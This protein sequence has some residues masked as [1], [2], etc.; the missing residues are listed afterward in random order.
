MTDRPVRHL[1][2]ALILV[3]LLL[4]LAVAVGAQETAESAA[5]AASTEAQVPADSLAIAEMDSSMPP[6]PDDPVWLELGSAVP[7][8]VLLRGAG[9]ILAFEDTFTFDPG[10]IDTVDVSAKRVTIGEVIEAIG[11]RMEAETRA[12]HN[13]EYTSLTTVVERDVPSR[14]GDDYTITEMADRTSFDNDKG[15]RSVQLWERVRTVEDGE[16]TEEEIDHEMQRDWGDMGASISM[17]MPFSRGSGNRY[18]YVIEDRALV[19]NS[20][21]Y[22]IAFAPKSRFEALPSGKV[23]VDYSHWVIRKLEAELVETVPFPMFLKAVPL[24]R[25]SRERHGG[26]WFTTDAHIVIEL[27]RIPL[28]DNPRQVE[29][30]T[31]LQ[32]IRINGE[33]V[34]EDMPVPRAERWGNLD[35]DDFWYSAEA[36]DDSLR[37][38]WEDVDAVWSAEVSDALT[39]VDLSEAQIDTLTE[40]GSTELERMWAASPWAFRPIEP[41]LPGYNRA[42][43]PVVRLG[44]RLWHRGPVRPEVKFMAGYA[45]ANEKPEFKVEARWPLVRGDVGSGPNMASRQAILDLDVDGWKEAR[46]FAGDG[47]RHTRSASAFFYGSDPN[48]YFESR[49]G[50]TRLTWRP[51]GGLALHGEAIYAEERTMEQNATWNLLGRQLRPDGVLPSHSL[52]DRRVGTGLAWRHKWLRLDGQVTWHHAASATFTGYW[53]SDTRDLR[54]LEVGG[55]IDVLDRAGNQWLL[56]GRHREFDGQA[57]RQ[58]RTWMGDWGTLRGYQHGELVGDAGTWGSVDLRLGWDIP[59]A[60]RLPLLKNWG[61]QTIGFADWARTRH[62]AGPWPEEGTAGERWDVGFGFGA[63]LDLP[64]TWGYPYLR[65]YVARPVG[66]GSEGHGWRFLVGVEV[67]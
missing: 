45:F 9:L 60:L 19:G 6:N 38:Y 28:V 10:E 29:I 4:A 65:T 24:V 35:P 12:M 13:V 63:R 39:P 53:P 42:Q 1:P 21:V 67:R 51:A 37:I 43:G 14:Y 16:I 59:R 46:L 41:R 17:A 50:L 61:I 26:Y 30:R 40:L 11:R 22:R 8:S 7:D 55:Q 23:W 2:V 33:P 64:I 58:W 44:A 18:N 48:S 66:E 3:I 27:R 5:P 31:R 54:E 25:I 52:D 20:L 56:K 62:E 15:R 32:D 47:R 34:A 57:P 49:G 36:S